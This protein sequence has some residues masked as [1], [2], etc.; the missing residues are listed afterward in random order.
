MQPDPTQFL[1]DAMAAR[2]ALDDR[3]HDTMQCIL[4]LRRIFPVAR[5]DTGR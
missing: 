5:V 4:G 1:V 3:R 2:S